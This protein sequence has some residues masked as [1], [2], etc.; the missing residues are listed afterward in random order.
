[1]SKVQ[2][3]LPTKK[4]HC[5]EHGEYESTGHFFNGKTM[6]SHCPECCKKLDDIE[7]KKEI[8]IPWITKRRENMRLE[9]YQTETDQ[10]KA[11]MNRIKKYVA[12]FKRVLEL[13]TCLCLAGSPGTGKTHLATAIGYA[14]MK[15]GYKVE[16]TRMYDLM[17]KIKNTYSRES[18]ITEDSIISN[19]MVFDLL[20]ID[21]VGLKTLT[22]TEVTLM[23]QIID[24]RYE[25][26]KPTI[27][28]SNLNEK[29]LELNLGERAM[30]RIYEN[31]GTVFEFKWESYR[32]LNKAA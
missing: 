2:A 1:M 27:I 25:A 9:T 4:T 31:H 29:E 12:N 32:R 13:G 15:S 21:E 11:I 8:A 23:H 14:V 17:R 28:V 16:Y 30:D 22:E 18:T 5:S 6:W 3:E 7:I 20:I 10:Q 24:T 26:V 19:L